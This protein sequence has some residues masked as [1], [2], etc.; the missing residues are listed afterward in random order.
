MIKLELNKINVVLLFVIVYFMTIRRYTNADEIL[1]V[2]LGI[3]VLIERIKEKSYF[4]IDKRILIISIVS[5]LILMFSYY[6]VNQI[7]D[8]S[9]DYIIVP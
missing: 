5:F 8:L 7:L 9:E 3:L 6:Q 1:I 2:V 4:L